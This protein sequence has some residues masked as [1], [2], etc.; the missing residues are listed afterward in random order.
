[1]AKHFVLSIKK[2]TENIMAQKHFKGFLSILYLLQ[3]ITN[4]ND[5]GITFL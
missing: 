4:L 2:N 5:V 1:M 3:N